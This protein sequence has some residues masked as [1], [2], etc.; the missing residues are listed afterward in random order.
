MEV[1]PGYPTT[2]L[3][4]PSGEHCCDKGAPPVGTSPGGTGEPAGDVGLT[5]AAE[6]EGPLGIVAT[7]STGKQ[8]LEPK[9]GTRLQVI[10]AA[11]SLKGVNLAQSKAC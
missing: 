7:K 10:F 2:I 11:I 8:I 1:A 5:G 4:R 3:K 6:F 9:P